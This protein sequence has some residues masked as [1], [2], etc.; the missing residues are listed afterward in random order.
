M[1]FAAEHIADYWRLPANLLGSMGA[2]PGDI[3]I[4]PVQGDSMAG[5]LVEGDCVFIDTRHRLPSPDG[6][7]ALSDEFGGIIVKRL[8]MASNPGTEEPIVR[9]ISDNPR[10]APKDW[11]LSDVRI[12][13][14]V[15]RK[16]G[17]VS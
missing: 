16:F 4:I 3:A 5:T 11:P 1:T 6:L 17:V 2:K 7:Y 10:H 8:E 15:L 13:G 12:V 9:V 14:R